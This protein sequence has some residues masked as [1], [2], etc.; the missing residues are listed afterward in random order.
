MEPP[1]PT[2]PAHPPTSAV[3][4]PT[5]A[6]PSPDDPPNIPPS[7]QTSRER[8]S[9]PRRNYTLLFRHHHHTSVK[10]ASSPSRRSL[11]L[12]R[13]REANP[14]GPSSSVL[15]LSHSADRQ[16]APRSSPRPHRASTAAEDS[17]RWAKARPSNHHTTPNL[18]RDGVPSRRPIRT[19][20]GRGR[21]LLGG[22][23]PR[24]AGMGGIMAP[25]R[26]NWGRGRCMWMLMSRRLVCSLGPGVRLFR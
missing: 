10:R 8:A 16:A 14:T 22:G 23:I 15:N 25:R 6:H 13:Q 26:G 20:V 1:S 7:V 9:P 19:R 2:A 11:R 12:L 5:E 17:P 21:L 3:R 18:P 24:R 4:H